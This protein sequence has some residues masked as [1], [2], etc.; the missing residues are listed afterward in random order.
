MHDDSD[1]RARAKAPH[2]LFMFNLIAF[3]LLLTPAVI[4]LGIGAWALALPPALSGVLIAYIYLRARRAP[5][6]EPPLVAGHWAVAWRRCRLLLYAYAATGALLLG[7]WGLAASN[8]DPSMQAIMFT[9]LTRVAVMP[10]VIMV[11][12]TA[13]L[14]SGAIYQAGRGEVPGQLPADGP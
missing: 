11:F 13:V 3:H 1:E 10:V 6:R 8:P 2:E 9:V 5:G 4:A 14:E 12:V 7:A